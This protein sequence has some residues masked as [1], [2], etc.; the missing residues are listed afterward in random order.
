MLDCKVSSHRNILVIGSDTASEP[1]VLLIVGL[2]GAGKTTCARMVVDY[3][4]C[5]LVHFGGLILSEVD[6][7]RLPRD[8]GSEKE[9]REDLRKMHGMA[10]IAVLSEPEIAQHTRYGRSVVVDGLYSLAELQHLQAQFATVVLAVHAP[11]S[12]RHERMAM[13]HE[14]PLA[15]DELDARDWQEVLTLDKAPP[16]ALAD[17]HILNDGSKPSLRVAVES[18]LELLGWARDECGV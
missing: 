15:P 9:V 6:R 13:R 16:I 8:Q 3:S 2:A 1:Q 14:R 18:Q 7:R 10:A 5:P 11:R 4:H 17:N 12:A